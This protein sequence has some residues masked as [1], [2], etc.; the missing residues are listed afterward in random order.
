MERDV[1]FNAY[2]YEACN[3]LFFIDRTT[4]RLGGEQKDQFEMLLNVPRNWIECQNV[5]VPKNQIE[6]VKDMI[7]RNKYPKGGQECGRLHC[8]GIYKPYR[9][10]FVATLD[11]CAYRA[12][13]AWL[14]SMFR[15]DEYKSLDIGST[16]YKNFSKTAHENGFGEL[17]GELA[18]GAPGDLQQYYS[19]LGATIL[20][21]YFPK[22]FRTQTQPYQIGLHKNDE[23]TQELNE[24]EQSRN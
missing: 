16:L 1:Q 3:D 20:P 17:S 15:E 22:R 14:R 11:G 7:A 6:A 18:V 24:I 23:L 8:G 13:Q 10:I 21:D 2:D 4:T 12:T 9:G 19:S 5:V